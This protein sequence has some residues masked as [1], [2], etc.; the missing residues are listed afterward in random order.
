[1]SRFAPPQGTVHGSG[2]NPASVYDPNGNIHYYTPSEYRHVGFGSRGYQPG[3][4][5]ETEYFPQYRP[6][7][8]TP[9]PTPEPGPT[10]EPTPVRSPYGGRS[11]ARANPIAA[12]VN[13]LMGAPVPYRRITSAPTPAPTGR[14]TQFGVVNNPPPVHT[15]YATPQPANVTSW[16]EANRDQLWQPEEG[17]TMAEQ[18]AR[19]NKEQEEAETPEP[20]NRYNAF[21][22]VTA[23]PSSA[24]SPT[25][26]GGVSESPPVAVTDQSQ[27]PMTHP[28]APAHTMP[29]SGETA[30]SPGLSVEDLYQTV[31]GRAPDEAGGA[32]WSDRL[33]SGDL[34]DV[35]G[36]FYA[37]AQ[38]EIGARQPSQP[39]NPAADF[40]WTA[41]DLYEDI[42]GRSPDEAGLAFWQERIASGENLDNVVDEFLASAIS[43]EGYADRLAEVDPWDEAGMN[44]ILGDIRGLRDRATGAGI[45]NTSDLMGDL[46]GNVNSAID[47]LYDTRNE[48]ETRAQELLSD[49]RERDFYDFEDIDSF[50][51]ELDTL[52]SE[53]DQWGATQATDEMDAI[54][55]IVARHRQRLE[56][57]QGRREAAD[58]ASAA[59]VAAQLQGHPRVPFGPNGLDYARRDEDN[60]LSYNESALARAL[61]LV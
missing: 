32:Y 51:G 47:N 5:G 4:D 34:G 16:G 57:E 11:T 58:R 17:E 9:E 44:A 27:A 10:P 40:D 46:F 53:I 31:L 35:L 3:G 61:G 15:A 22:V 49:T 20:V 7:N 43:G 26:A 30:Q 18:I 56:S 23:N 41:T 38:D 52:L 24:A 37:A 45:D 60:L 55:E 14:Y 1:M 50:Q 6:V 59:M 42:L 33:A 12:F 19:W 13:S 54:A 48:Y 39:Q 25:T 29:S 8:T 36:E 21:G 2:R 28:G